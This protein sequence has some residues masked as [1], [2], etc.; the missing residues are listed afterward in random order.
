MGA[1]HEGHLS[2]CR[3][4]HELADAVVASVFVNPLQFGPGEDFESYPRDLAGDAA[5]LESAGVDLLFTMQAAEMYP[6]GY[7][8]HVDVEG[9]L[10]DGL[11]AGSRPGHFRGVTTVVTKLLGI[12]RPDV[13]LFGQKD[14]QQALV[15]R[16]MAADL[17]L[18][19]ELVVCPTVRE[20]DGLAMSSRNAYLDPAERQSAL[21]LSRGLRSALER[22]E[23]GEQD[24][25]ALEECV[26]QASAGD[27]LLRWDYVEVRRIP[28]LARFDQ[29]AVAAPLA[30]LCA[31]RVGRARL[32]DNLVHPDDA[33]A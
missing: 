8:T 22:F 13:A 9:P 27:P 19:V 29:G 21:A 12:V 1:L 33:L 15:L 20:T 2:L 18:G 23:A 11:C 24:R 17:E 6:P 16:R 3:R 25:S 14:L 10:V 30:M 4:G 28:D 5:K 32:I 26:R 31:A 7:S